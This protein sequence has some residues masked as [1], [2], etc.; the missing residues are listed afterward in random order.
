MFIYITKLAFFHQKS[1]LSKIVK[2]CQKISK[3]DKLKIDLSKM[4]LRENFSKTKKLIW[5]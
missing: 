4:Y 5:R 1:R 3:I 2:N